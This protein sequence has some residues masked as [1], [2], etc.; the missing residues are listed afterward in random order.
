MKKHL[1]LFSAITIALMALIGCGQTERV[2]VSTLFSE[3]TAISTPT[4]SSSSEQMIIVPH[5]LYIYS[6]NEDYGLVL[7]K[8][9]QYREPAAQY[10]EYRDYTTSVTIAAYSKT[11]VRFLGW[12]NNQNRL[13]ESSPTYS[14]S[15]PNHDYEL[16]AKWSYFKIEYNLNGGVNHPSNPDHYGTEVKEITLHAPTKVGHDFIGWKYKDNYVSMIESSWMKNITLEAFWKPTLSDDGKT[17]TYGLYPQTNVNDSSLIAA[18]DVLTSPESNG[19]YLY[20]G[21]Y[22]AKVSATPLSSNYYFDNRTKIV[23]GTTY[24][25]KCEPITWNVLS[26]TNSEYYILSSVLLDHQCY[27]NYRNSTFYRTIDGETICPSN[28]EYSDIRNWLN[29]DF[30]NSAL[31]LGYHYSYIQTTIVDNSAATTKSSSNSYVCNNT[32]DKVFLPSYQDYI[33]SNYGF[34]T[35]LSRCCKPTDWAIARGAYYCTFTGSY[36]RNGNYWTRSPSSDYGGKD[37][38]QYVTDEGKI[39]YASV[40]GHCCV[41]PAITIKI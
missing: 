31:T 38:A 33:N 4:S 26:N 14:F 25:F 15:M 39:T 3:Q 40:D 17:I 27:Y 32:Q 35:D 8:S 36:H 28:Y 18:L 12:Y 21:D 16:E 22:Y 2:T 1:G 9:P 24:W 23:S 13:V 30:Y 5:R 10:S 19:W 6:N 29:N 7:L 41:R 20:N 11:D 37:S 34:R